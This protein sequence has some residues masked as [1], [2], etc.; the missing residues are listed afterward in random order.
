MFASRRHIM[1]PFAFSCQAE[2]FPFLNFE[3]EFTAP[4]GSRQPKPWNTLDETVDLMLDSDF[5]VES[6]SEIG[7][8]S[9]EEEEMIDA[10]C[11][12]VLESANIRYVIHIVPCFLQ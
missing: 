6:G 5:V 9:S 12:P 3:T 1:T 4:M 7:D 11:D 10:G 8:L 2:C